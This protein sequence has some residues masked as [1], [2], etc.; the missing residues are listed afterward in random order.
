LGRLYLGEGLSDALPQLLT[1]EKLSG[2]GK[3]FWVEVDSLASDIDPELV[4]PNH[5]RLDRYCAMKILEQPGGAGTDRGAWK[6][7][8]INFAGELPRLE[9]LFNARQPS[10]AGYAADRP[11]RAGD[12]MSFLV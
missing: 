5:T 4:M 1:A 11:W 2:G 12:V 3:A 6:V 9:A 10:F 7:L 8:L